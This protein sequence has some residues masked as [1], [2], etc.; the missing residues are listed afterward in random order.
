[1]DQLVTCLKITDFGVNYLN[2]DLSL[3]I[4]AFPYFR[5]QLLM[6]INDNI[7]K[8]IATA[9]NADSEVNMH[10]TVSLVTKQ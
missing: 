7:F 2:H 1:M 6:V 4:S 3:F 9:S 5:S 10:Q 8:I